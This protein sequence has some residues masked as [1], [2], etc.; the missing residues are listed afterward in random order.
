M[1]TK[2]FMIFLLLVANNIV[3]DAQDLNT[4][5]MDKKSF[6]ED[7][8]YAAWLGSGAA[9]MHY[10]SGIPSCYAGGFEA[11]RKKYSLELKIA[12]LQ[13]EWI[14]RTFPPY[15]AEYYFKESETDWNFDLLFK[16]NVRKLRSKNKFNLITGLGYSKAIFT[17]PKSILTDYRTVLNANYVT[18]RPNLISIPLGFSYDFRIGDHFGI[19]NMTLWNQSILF[20]RVIM[21]EDFRYDINA[22]GTRGYGIPTYISI[23]LYLKYY[24]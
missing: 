17:F 21:K 12:R 9:E 15:G 4:N 2:L 6:L 5:K 16:Y 11:S 8:K 23:L 1:R 19:G 18:E 20:K 7:L 24:F 22:Y 14:S 3:L 13:G 10:L